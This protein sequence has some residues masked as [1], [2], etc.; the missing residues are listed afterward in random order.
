MT[1]MDAPAQTTEDGVIVTVG[2]NSGRA[3]TLDFF[4]NAVV[5]EAGQ[6]V[7]WVV[8]ENLMAE[9]GVGMS[10]QPIG[11]SRFD[12][13]PRLRRSPSSRPMAKIRPSIRVS[14]GA[15]NPPSGSAVTLDSQWGFG[16][17]NPGDSYTLTFSEPGV[18]RYLN[19]A[20]G[21]A[22][23]YVIVQASR[24]VDEPSST[25]PPRIFGEDAGWIRCPSI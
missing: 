13:E 22:S 9:L 19:T 2:L 21:E 6:S 14:I 7:T 8:P 17:M 23:G 15:A 3:Q 16:W 1:A 5:I 25:Y 18:Y 11:V 10:S 24:L 4:P 12:Q 20:N